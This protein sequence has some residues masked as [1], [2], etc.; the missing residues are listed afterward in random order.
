MQS[1]NSLPKAIFR[2]LRWIAAKTWLSLFPETEVI[3]V[4]GSVG[5]TTTKEIIAS[6]LGEKFRTTKTTA[7]LD[8]IFNLPLT[9]F[10]VRKN[11]KFIAEL[12]VDQIGQMDKYLTFIKPRVG[13][14][15]KLSIEHADKDHFG[16]CKN[17]VEEEVKLIKSLPD[18]GWLV[19]NGDEQLTKQNAK[20]T[21]AKVLLCGFGKG[22]D[23]QITSFCQKIVGNRAKSVYLVHYKNKTHTVESN[24]LGWY[25]ALAVSYGIAVG[26]IYDLDFAEIQQGVLKVSPVEHRLQPKK[27]KWGVVI[28]DTYNAIPAAVEGAID[29][30]VDLDKKNPTLVLGEMKELG[31]YSKDQHFQIGKYAK[32]KGIKRLAI[33]GDHAND[34]ILGFGGNKTNCLLVKNHQEVIQWL[35]K[36]KPPIVLIKGSRSM[37]MEKIVEAICS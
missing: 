33:L 26:I 22:N 18:L 27:S 8:P 32:E 11:T 35:T 30:L 16:S 34:V 19:T 6:I 15:T 14:V 24:L 28:D 5:K 2:T 21:K 13:V 4:A 7:N 1:T 23:L 25:N 36:T 20:L 17:A 12:S 9:A 10:K 29:V 3:G 37:Q 31:E